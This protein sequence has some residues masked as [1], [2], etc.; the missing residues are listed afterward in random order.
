MLRALSALIVLI[1]LAV[2]VAPSFAQTSQGEASLKGLT[3]VYLRVVGN[4]LSSQQR[5]AFTSKV[6]LELRKA[7]IHIAKDP[8]DLAPNDGA[9]V[10]NFHQLNRA[11]SQD[12]TLEWLLLEQVTLNRTGQKLTL[13]TWRYVDDRRATQPTQVAEPMLRGA[14]DKFLN[15][16]LSAN[17]R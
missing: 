14:I 13:V 9:I 3:T 4:S 1:G 17:G 6:S 8:G 12:L 7:G 10:V 2:P 16:W 11:L 5:E 15:A